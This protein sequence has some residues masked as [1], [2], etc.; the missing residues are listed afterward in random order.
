MINIPL[1]QTLEI[2]K[3]GDDFAMEIA[4]FIKKADLA[5]LCNFQN[6]SRDNDV[7]FFNIEISDFSVENKSIRRSDFS[8]SKISNVRFCRT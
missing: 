8:F 5:G 6:S 2:M 1:S 7:K 3:Q 4:E